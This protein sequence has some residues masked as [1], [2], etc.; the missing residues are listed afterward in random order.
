MP[1]VPDVARELF[2]KCQKKLKWIKKEGFE[3]D[4]LQA[5]ADFAGDLVRDAQ[6]LSEFLEAE[7]KRQRQPKSS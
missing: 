3:L 5:A 6:A 4:N 1:Q 2:A 7:L